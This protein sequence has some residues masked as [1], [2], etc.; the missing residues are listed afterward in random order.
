MSSETGKSHRNSHSQLCQVYVASREVRL[1]TLLYPAASQIAT[2]RRK[3]RHDSLTIPTFCF[4]TKLSASGRKLTW[5]EANF[6][7]CLSHLSERSKMSTSSFF[8]SPFSFSLSLALHVTDTIIGQGHCRGHRSQRESESTSL[9]NT[10]R[11][12]MKMTTFHGHILWH[13]TE[14]QKKMQVKERKTSQRKRIKR[15]DEISAFF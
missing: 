3:S 11:N 5:R 8:R 6:I 14:Q 12:Q 15:G 7:R 10:R 2:I 13:V 9:S 4:L 1:A